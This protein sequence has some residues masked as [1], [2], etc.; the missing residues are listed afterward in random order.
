MRVLRIARTALVTLAAHK[1]RS[2][3]MM[4]G[5]IIGVAT[6]NIVFSAVLGARATVMQGVEKFGLDSLMIMAGAG[7]RPGV[8][9]AEPVTLRVGD[10]EAMAAEIPNV[11]HV[12]P[13]I[14]RRE[15]P[16]KR[17]NKS[18][19]SVVVAAP[20]IWSSVWSTEVEEGRFLEDEDV[21]RR[22]RVA[23]IGKTIAS[24]LFDGEDPIGKKINLASNIF[25]VTGILESRG[26]SVTGIDMDSRIVIPLTTGQK[27]VFNQEH[28]RAIKVA[29][30]D[31]SIMGQTVEDIRSL[32]RERH[33]LP[34]GAED[35][36]TIV[37]PTK[38]IAMAMKLSSTFALFLVLVSGVSLTV[39]GIVLA[40]IMFIAVHERKREIGLRR[41]IGARKKDILFQFLLEA[42]CVAFLGGIIG[43]GLGMAGIYILKTVSKIPAFLMWQP[44]AL[45]LSS[46]LVV[47][48]LS[49]YLP[50]RRAANIDPSDALR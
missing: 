21:S 12:C 41:A 15:V 30:R 11:K 45:A 44:V 34:R 16:V 39:G 35:D 17:G 27:R 50:A 2:L 7:R 28:V 48:L 8:I 49:G 5:V 46:A 42:L 40:N 32:L 31:A 20:A 33:H 6:Q 47:G 18:S 3:L 29:V 22:A 26:T 9:Q 38:V 36:F 1:T 14:M 13:Q 43:L 23:V 4:L 25:E 24:D 10:A 37:T 19:Y